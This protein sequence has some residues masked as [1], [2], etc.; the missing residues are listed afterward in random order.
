MEK[1]EIAVSISRQGRSDPARSGPRTGPWTTPLQALRSALDSPVGGRRIEEMRAPGSVAI[2][3]PD[4]SR[5][6][7]F[8]AILTALLERLYRAYGHLRPEKHQHRHRGRP[9]SAF[10][11][12]PRPRRIG[13]D[14]IRP[15]VAGW[16][17]MMP[18]IRHS[19][20]SAGPA[21]VPPVLV[22]AAYGGADLKIV[23]GQID[24]HQ[25]VGF[26]GGAKGVVIGCA[27]AKT[28]EHNHGMMDRDGTGAGRLF[29]NPVREDLN[30][31]GRLVGVDF[32]VNAVVGPDKELVGL[33]AG[34]P[35][36]VLLEGAKVCE[37]LYGVG[38]REPFDFA[39]RLLRRTSQGHLPL[40]GAEGAQSLL[41]CR[42]TPR[43]ESRSSRECREGCRGRRLLSIYMPLPNPSK[44]P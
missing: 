26:T 32:A 42:E 16:S 10:F 6:I 5:P 7:P 20:I 21:A 19:W 15:P 2:A 30:E 8:R 27:S 22:N 12:H 17:F 13:S 23:V 29:G 4:P 37:K 35:E 24:P 34:D 44:R 28:I 11:F 31:A 36:G 1:T 14:R 38:I 39:P 40:P 43:A 18:I 25:F 41:Q 33:W 3:V 9:A